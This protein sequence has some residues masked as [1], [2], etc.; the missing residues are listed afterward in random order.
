MKSFK[1]C[2]WVCRYETKKYVTLLFDEVIEA[3]LVKEAI[4][5]EKRSIY[6]GAT[7]AL[8]KCNVVVAVLDGIAVEPGVAFEI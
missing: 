8:K 4:Y 2:L 1:T 5:Q 6:E 7:T 3:P